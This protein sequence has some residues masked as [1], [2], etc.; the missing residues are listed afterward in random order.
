MSY[1]LFFY[2]KKNSKLTDSEIKSELKRL[3]PKNISEI[4]NQIHYSNERTG[5]YFLIDFNEP[6]TE[7]EDIEVFDNFP[8]FENT[9][10]SASINFLRPDYFGKEIFPIIGDFSNRLDLYILNSQE[11]NDSRQKPLKWA[12]SELIDHWTSHNAMVSKQ[13]FN[14]L[15]LN[16]LDK[17]KSDYLWSY[18][19]QIERLENEI[20]DDIYIPNAFVIKNKDTKELYTYIAWSQS[21]PLV[22]PKVDFIII[23]KKYKKLFR[24]IKEIGI[25]RYQDIL[26]RFVS[27]FEVFDAENGLL[28][29][30]QINADKIKNDFNAFPL[31]KSH[32]DFGPQI[33]LDGFVNNR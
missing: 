31:W 26:D 7:K 30:K 3:I 15:E 5:V 33:A 28:L 18:T 32:K 13:Q 16:Y 29:L 4:D 20:K 17:A 21:I 12:D 23:L 2:R 8:D 22:L 10:L 24:T 9:N 1:D 14:E 25:V 11:V 19:S 6:N 27:D